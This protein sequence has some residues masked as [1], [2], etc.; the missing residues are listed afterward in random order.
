MVDFKT[1]QVATIERINRETAEV[2]TTFPE[3]DETSDSFDPELSD[4]IYDAVEAKIK[5]DPT[6]SVK[7]FV[8]KQM[9]LF[10]REAA[11]EEQ[12]TG[13]VISKQASQAAIRPSN[14]KP[15]DTKFENLSIAEMEQ[16]LGYAS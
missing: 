11:R 7:T 8:S 4:A 2:V 13:E 6:A 3:L 1:R 12:Q 16:K 15:V 14:N 9:K 10:K 5:S